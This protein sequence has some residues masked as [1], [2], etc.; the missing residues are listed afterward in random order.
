LTKYK[1]NE[2][3][4]NIKSKE[5]IKVICI[6]TDIEYYERKS[7]HCENVETGKIGIYSERELEDEF[8]SISDLDLEI[9]LIS[10]NLKEM[11]SRIDELKWLKQNMYDTLKYV[12]KKLNGDSKR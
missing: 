9:G 4:I 2:A 5:V 7:Y 8:R 1:V 12:N 10:Y 6:Y 11:E 3:L